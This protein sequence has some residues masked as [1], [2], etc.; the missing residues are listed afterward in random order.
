[1]LKSL[2]LATV[3]SLL[4]ALGANGLAHIYTK[5]SS[6][7]SDKHTPVPFIVL[8]W[9][10]QSGCRDRP[11]YIQTEYPGVV[12]MAHLVRCSLHKL[13][14]LSSVPQHPPSNVGVVACACH[15]STAATGA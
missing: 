8:R 9:Q 2:R 6:Y 3:N 1:M 12:E 4:P 7:I 13:E 11:M 10:A 15:P 5:S 14:D